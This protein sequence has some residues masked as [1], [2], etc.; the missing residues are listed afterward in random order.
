MTTRGNSM[1]S[2]YR[3]SEGKQKR[4]G[5]CRF[6]LVLFSWMMLAQMYA[7]LIWF[8]C[9]IYR[10]SSIFMCLSISRSYYHGISTCLQGLLSRAH[11][12]TGKINGNIFKI[13]YLINFTTFRVHLVI[14]WG[15]RRRTGLLTWIHFFNHIS[16]TYK[17]DKKRDSKV[18]KDEK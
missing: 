16:P 1:D 11:L 7:Q 15:I 5:Q 17:K 8:C 13:G 4:S 10:L 6:W 12:L 3:N 18:G 2:I 9:R 14:Q